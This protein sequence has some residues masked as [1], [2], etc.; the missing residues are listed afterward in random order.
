MLNKIKIV[1]KVLPIETKEKEKR[2]KNERVFYFSLLVPNPSGSLTILRC[3]A[4]REVAEVIEKEIKQ[5]EI[6]EVRGYLRNEKSG[7]QVLV[8]V[9][10]FTKLDI[11]LDEVD[12]NYSNQVRLLGKIVTDF[13][14]RENGRDPEVLSFRVAVPREGNNLPFFFCRVQGAG[15]IAEVND[16]LK[17]NDIVLLE[18]F[19]QTKKIVEEEKISRISSIICQT[20]TLI[21][22]DSVS[23]FNP[24]DKFTRIVGEIERIDFAKPK[25]K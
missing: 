18:G 12:E 15:L 6:I 25:E 11:T 19:L 2:E 16:K 14:V 23:I 24:L 22:N 1:G 8:K 17:R 9:V 10:E 4:Q 3:A 20:F 5:D 13:K 21:D 7:R